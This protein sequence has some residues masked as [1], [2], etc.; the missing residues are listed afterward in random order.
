MCIRDRLHIAPS[1]IKSLISQ[2]VITVETESYYRNPVRL[3][4]G[5]REE[6]KLSSE[7]QAIVDTVIADRDAGICKT[8]L[9]HGITAVSYTHLDYEAY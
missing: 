4:A 3:E 7:Q 1:T 5:G 6:K 8:Y 9:I 2:Q